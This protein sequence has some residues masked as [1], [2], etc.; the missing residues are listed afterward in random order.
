MNST[1]YSELYGILLM[2]GKS[3]ISKLPLEI[4]DKIKSQ[5]DPNYNPEYYSIND[6]K[7]GIIS[8]IT[9]EFLSKLYLEYW[10]NN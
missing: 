3:Y 9:L 6:I 10:Q 5:K 7:D 8:N 1:D 2:L 4:I